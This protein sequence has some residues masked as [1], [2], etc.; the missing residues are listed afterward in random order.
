VELGSRRSP[1]LSILTALVSRLQASDRTTASI[2]APRGDSPPKRVFGPSPANAV[3]AEVLRALWDGAL[4]APRA[5]AY[6]ASRG[7]LAAEVRADLD[8]PASV[9][10]V[11]S[12]AIPRDRSLAIFVACAE[13]SG[14]IHAVNFVRALQRRIASAGAPPPRLSGLGGD[15]LAN[16]G[17]ELLGRPVDRAQMGFQ[18]IASSLPYYTGL[19]RDAAAHVRD[20]RPDVVC[21]VDSPALHVPLLRIAHRYDARTLHFVTPQYWGWAPWRVKSYKTGVDRALSI[22][23]FER[24]WFERR[25]VSIAH[26]GHPLLDELAHVPRTTPREDANELVLLPGSRS[27]VI[28]RNLPWMLAAAE[29]L[30]ARVGDVPVVVAHERSEIADE[31]G[32]HIERAGAASWARLETGDLHAILSRA[33][34]ALS[35]SGTVLLDLLHHDLPAVVL[36]R[37][38][39]AREV[40]LKDRLL[41]VPWFSSI[42]LLAAS[43]VYPEFAF[44]GDGPI[45]RIGEALLGC[46]NDRAW[47][48]RCRAGLALA[49]ERLGP[50][51][52]CDR[53]AAHALALACRA[54]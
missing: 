10:P 5:I 40:W 46:Y 29:R 22:L 7:R 51:G 52:A 47:R 54:T 33:R 21:A 50:A 18:G 24:A 41:T 44:H 1:A 28:A 43:E 42:N 6:V 53:A 35:V 39:H 2:L 16:A 23:P 9:D 17:V 32:A 37:L 26:V 12:V 20:T 38:A 11:P 48:D 25:G 14:E 31:I 34:A 36:Y 3:R 19:L 15:R 13:V 8:H 30:R 49:R 4:L 27:R 45:D